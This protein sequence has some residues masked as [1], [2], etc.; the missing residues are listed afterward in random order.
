[1]WPK[2]LKSDLPF[3]YREYDENQII[4][5]A[6]PSAAPPVGD[7]SSSNHRRDGTCSSPG[8]GIVQGSTE[9]L[10]YNRRDAAVT[11]IHS[12]APVDRGGR[13]SPSPVPRAQ[14]ARCSDSA[15]TGSAGRSDA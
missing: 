3:V 7:R 9:P 2:I 4:S 13:L 10:S 6:G 5:L 12:R 11:G 8:F 14:R 15:G 1:M